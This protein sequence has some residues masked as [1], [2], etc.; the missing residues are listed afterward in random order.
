MSLPVV[1]RYSS[2]YFFGKGSES[3]TAAIDYT[4]MDWTHRDT[5]I[6]AMVTARCWGDAQYRAEVFANPRAVLTEEGLRLPEGLEL[7]VVGSIVEVDPDAAPDV[8]YVV[9]PPAPSGTDMAGATESE[10]VRHAVSVGPM[11]I[12]PRN[13]S[14][15]PD[16]AA[17]TAEVAAQV[18]AVTAVAEAAEVLTSAAAVAEAV[19]VAT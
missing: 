7:R 15:S 1:V 4:L 16:V 3:V 18:G 5:T 6:L 14:A 12:D 2:T 10:L 9:L 19:I 8:R 11:V 13:A 17:V